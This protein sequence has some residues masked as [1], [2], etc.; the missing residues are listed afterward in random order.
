MGS[1]CTFNCA[2]ESSTISKET[3]ILD[4]SFGSSSLS[5]ENKLGDLLTCDLS[6]F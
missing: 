2:G 6:F 3:P 4:V 5:E 1:G